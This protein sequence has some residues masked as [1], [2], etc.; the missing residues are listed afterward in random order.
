MECLEDLAQ[1]VHADLSTVMLP[2]VKVIVNVVE[3]E[4]EGEEHAAIMAGTM[5]VNIIMANKLKPLL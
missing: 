2:A 1:I 4:G 3:R 5:C